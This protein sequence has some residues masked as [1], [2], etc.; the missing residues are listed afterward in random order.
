MVERPGPGSGDH[1]VGRVR[2]R[3]ARSRRELSRE[4]LT[5][6]PHF[7]EGEAPQEGNHP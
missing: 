7:A 1:G 5:D 6:V 2:K 4:I 3:S